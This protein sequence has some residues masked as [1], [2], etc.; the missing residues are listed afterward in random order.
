MNVTEFINQSK[1]TL[2]LEN[3]VDFQTLS[4]KILDV[5]NFDQLSY[6]VIEMFDFFR[7]KYLNYK[8]IHYHHC[9]HIN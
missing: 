6:L 1:F 2:S 3:H 8:H 9:Q 5:D 4:S 7:S